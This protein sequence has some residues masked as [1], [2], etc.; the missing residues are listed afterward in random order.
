MN[1]KHNWEATSRERISGAS[2]VEIQTLEFILL[3]HL[4]RDDVLSHTKEFLFVTLGLRLRANGSAKSQLSQLNESRVRHMHTP[5]TRR[6]R[7]RRVRSVQLRLAE[8]RRNRSVLDTQI[9]VYSSL[10]SGDG[11]N[12]TSEGRV[13]LLMQDD[14]FARWHSGHFCDHGF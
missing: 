14:G 13:Q 12:K 7:C 9:L 8:A 2:D 6:V 11:M 10:L 5:M 4:A 3:E 1:E